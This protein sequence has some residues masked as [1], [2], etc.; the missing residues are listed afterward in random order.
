M[1]VGVFARFLKHALLLLLHEHSVHLQLDRTRNKGQK[2]NLKYTYYGGYKATL[3]VLYS[4]LTLKPFTATVEN[5]SLNLLLISL[6]C[7]L[8]II[9]YISGILSLAKCRFSS[10][11]QLNTKNVYYNLWFDLLSLL[12]YSLNNIIQLSLHTLP[13]WMILQLVHG[14]LSVLVM[15]LFEI[16]VHIN[17]VGD[18]EHDGRKFIWVI[19][20]IL[21]QV[22]DIV[23]IFILVFVSHSV[24]LL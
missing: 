21:D 23:D 12:W 19:V 2:L 7:N 6:L 18:Q 22:D 1:E 16:L 11:S 5:Q 17:T 8:D 24:I 15:E 3:I 10:N 20:S 13:Q 4:N 14:T 9:S